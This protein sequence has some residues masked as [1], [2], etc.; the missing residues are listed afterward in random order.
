MKQPEWFGS[1]FYTNALRQFDKA[2]EIINLDANVRDRLRYP[3]RCLIVDVPVRMDDGTIK[4]YP[5]Y[6]VQHNMTLGPAKGGMRYHPTVDLSEVSALAFLMTFKCSLVGLPL[7]GGKG[8]IKCD[9]TKFSRGEK[10]RLTRRFTTEILPIIGPD[11]DIPAPDVNTDAQTMAWMM[12]TYSQEV[13]YTVP[14][15][16]TGKPV[17]IGG[18]LGREEATGRGVIYSVIEAAKYLNMSLDKNTTVVI[19]G[20]GNV[21][22]HA[23]RKIHKIGCTVTAISDVSGGY[24]NEKGLDIEAAYAHVRERGTLQDWTGGDKISNAELLEIPCDIQIP[25]AIEG[26]ITKKNAGKIKCK[27]MAEGANGPTT[28]DADEI[29]INNGVFIIPDVLANSGG[30]TV[31]YFE[32]VQ[33]IQKLFWTEKEVNQRLF[34]LMSSSFAKV[35]SISDEYKTDMRTAALISGVVRLRDAMLNRGFFP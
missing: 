14:G 26:V 18:S 8:G 16:V 5:G 12:D 17:A 9:P 31:S 22:I 24:Y 30:V 23:A 6:R 25:A 21:G 27:I 10:Q 29:L 33:G 11:R 1:E 32:W 20:F 15:V 35:L 4:N 7:G 19:Q 28:T 3:K 2:A 34:E 13:G